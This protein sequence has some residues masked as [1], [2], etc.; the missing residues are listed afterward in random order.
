M[1]EPSRDGAHRRRPPNPFGDFA[2]SLNF[3]P[4]T[5]PHRKVV[6]RITRSLESSCGM[7]LVSGEIG[8]GKTSVGLYVREEFGGPLRLRTPGQPVPEPRRARGGG[9]GAA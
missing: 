7:V 2:P 1:A 9:A 6:H 4:S 5:Q 8:I 3:Y